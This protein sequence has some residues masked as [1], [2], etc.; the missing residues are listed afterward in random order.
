M[1]TT[2]TDRM[3]RMRKRR[4][5]GMQIVQTE[6][7]EEAIRLLEK[8]GYLLTRSPASIGPAVTALLSDL[9]LEAA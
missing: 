6:I 8:Q 2:S 1:K 7:S 9:V 4:R 5:F 3:R